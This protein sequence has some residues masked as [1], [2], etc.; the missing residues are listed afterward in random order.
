MLEGVALV[1]MNDDIFVIPPRTLVTI[2]P[3]VPHTWTACPPGVSVGSK[4]SGRDFITSNGRFLMLYEYEDSTA[5]FP[6]RQT[7]TLKSV[8]DYE[9][10]DEGELESIRIPAL[11]ADEV[12]E[13]CWF[14]W[15]RDLRKRCIWNRDLRKPTKAG[16]TWVDNICSEQRFKDDTMKEPCIISLIPR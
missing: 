11:T 15:N 9:A 10:C 2:A 1:Q 7:H 12:N 3:G 16:M 6:T 14:I 13:R 5:F 8:E 4:D